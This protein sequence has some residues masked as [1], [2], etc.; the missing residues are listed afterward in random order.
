MSTVKS[1]SLSGK[2]I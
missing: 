2:R 1:Q